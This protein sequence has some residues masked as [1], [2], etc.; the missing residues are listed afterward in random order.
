MIK[1]RAH[2][3]ITD[4][5][6]FH[7]INT[8]LMFRVLLNPLSFYLSNWNELSLPEKDELP[9]STTKSRNVV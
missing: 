1:V 9:K 6:K 5:K 7:D 3:D 2:S 8:V 4:L